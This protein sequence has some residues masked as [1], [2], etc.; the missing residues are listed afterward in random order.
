MPPRSRPPLGVWLHGVHIADL[1]ADRH[2]WDLRCRYTDEALD[3]WP[4]NTP[5]LSCSLPLG[6]R[7]LPANPFCNGL[8]PEGQHRQ[9]C[10]SNLGVPVTYTYALLDRHGRDIAGAAVI[11]RDPPDQRPG[12]VEWHTDETL[13]AEVAGIDQHPLGIHDDSELSLAGLEDK[14]T[15]VRD[16]DRWGRPRHGY[17]STHIVKLDNTRYAGIVHA[18]HDCMVLARAVGLT[19]IDTELIR[20]AGVDCLVVSRYD[21]HVPPDGAVTRIHQEDACQALG[22]DLAAGRDRGKYE[23]A[24]GP[25]LA[26]IAGLLDRYSVDPAA[27]LDRLV[28][29]VTFTVA[30]GNADA[31]GKNLSLLH[32]VPGQIELAPLYDTVPTVLWP[33]LRSRTAMAVAGKRRLGTITVDD[34]A[35][36][37]ATWP[38]DRAQARRAAV[39][40]V[41]RLH[42]A[43]AAPAIDPESRVAQAVGSHLDVLGLNPGR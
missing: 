29:A 7:P 13:A 20:I 39:T 25:S 9:A 17:P 2:Q 35:D 6:R 33:A 22:V 4:G 31:H 36:E 24:G 18:E 32:H 14:F 26:A 42:D 1:T 10:A 8:L 12:S 23:D 34:I 19:T 27:Q 3:R 16:G 15:V 5:L 38:Y 41:E 40:L 28:Q 43:L 30:I 11:S 37:A 21:R